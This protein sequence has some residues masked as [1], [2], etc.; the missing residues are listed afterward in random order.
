MTTK[1]YSLRALWERAGKPME[2]TNHLHDTRMFRAAI[3]GPVLLSLLL[4]II[5]QMNSGLEPN[6][7]FQ[8]FNTFLINFKLPIGFAG[9]AIPLGALVASHHRSIQAASQIESQQNQNTFSNYVKHKE[10]FEK[11]LDEQGLLTGNNSFEAKDKKIYHVLFPR[12]QNGDFNFKLDSI[13]HEYIE[14]KIVNLTSK[15]QSFTW[16]EKS[17]S[18]DLIGS[19]VELKEVVADQF[20]LRISDVIPGTSAEHLQ[21]QV[22]NLHSAFSDIYTAATFFNEN[23]DDPMRIYDWALHTRTLSRYFEEIK[24]YEYVL[25]RIKEISEK[26][27]AGSHVMVSEAQKDD[28]LSLLGNDAKEKLSQIESSLSHLPTTRTIIEQLEH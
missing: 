6:L 18:E 24:K 23:D 16:R 12:A 7:S 4:A 9:L 3:Y 2:P 10:Y 27:N 8:G 17:N 26:T 25:K 22:V 15:V 21:S 13:E 19:L 20:D 28:F 14:E 5:G 1:K 11:F